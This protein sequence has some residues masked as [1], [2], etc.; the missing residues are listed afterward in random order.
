ML[1]KFSFRQNIAQKRGKLLFWRQF[2]A[3]I[4]QIKL[5]WSKFQSENTPLKIFEIILRSRDMFWKCSPEVC[6]S[7]H[8]KIIY[9]A[10]LLVFKRVSKSTAWFFCRIS[11]KKLN[12]NLIPDLNVYNNTFRLEYWKN[13]N[14]SI[15]AFK[16]G[17]RLKFSFFYDIL[18]KNHAVDLD[19]LF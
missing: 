5:K 16:S 3:K 15:R 19:T 7:K 8:T 9:Q 18:Q 2:F 6:E 12:F 10:Y 17:I 14:S 11:W 4:G 1:S 13:E